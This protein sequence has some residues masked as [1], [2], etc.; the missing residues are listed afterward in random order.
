LEQ[1]AV[2]QFGQDE[3]PMTDSGM[4]KPEHFQR[5]DRCRQ[6]VTLRVN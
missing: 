3:K 6:F 5:H 4:P 2:M 1:E